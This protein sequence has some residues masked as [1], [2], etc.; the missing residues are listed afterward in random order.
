MRPFRRDGRMDRLGAPVAL[1]LD[2]RKVRLVARR[3]RKD[4]PIPL[5]LGHAASGWP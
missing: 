1:E 3:A 2:G 4:F 5:S